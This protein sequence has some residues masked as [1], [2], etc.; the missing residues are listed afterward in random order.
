[1]PTEFSRPKEAV[2]PEKEPTTTS[3]AWRPPS[4]Y[5]CSG[6][7]AGDGE[8]AVLGVETSLLLGGSWESMVRG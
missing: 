3:Q 6:S 5:V 2:M 8:L 7:E 1:M 4:G